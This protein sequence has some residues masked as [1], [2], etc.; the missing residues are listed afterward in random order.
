MVT[1]SFVFLL[2]REQVRKYCNSA[3]RSLQLHERAMSWP[4]IQNKSCMLVA[5]MLQQ[6][7]Y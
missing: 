4:V 5:Y 6:L 1:V 7:Y 3:Q 2:L